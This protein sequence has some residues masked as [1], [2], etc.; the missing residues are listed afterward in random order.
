MSG[1]ILKDTVAALVVKTRGCASKQKCINTFVWFSGRA[2]ENPVVVWI[3]VVFVG[4][5]HCQSQD[6]ID[7]SNG[8]LT[9]R[10]KS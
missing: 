4:R 9:C 2:I 3:P 1:L 5:S 10:M 8:V 7:G 6:V